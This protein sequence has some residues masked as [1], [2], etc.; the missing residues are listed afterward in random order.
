MESIEHRIFSDVAEMAAFTGEAGILY[1]LVFEDAID[2]A[3]VDKFAR[4]R[5]AC[6]RM[7]ALKFCDN[8][9]LFAHMQAPRRLPSVGAGA[10]RCSTMLGQ[11]ARWTVF[12]ATL[13][14]GR[15]GRVFGP[16]RT[17]ELGDSTGT[18]RGEK[19]S[20]V[21]VGKAGRTR[22][23][24]HLFPAG[25]MRGQAGKSWPTMPAPKGVR[26]ESPGRSPG[27]GRIEPA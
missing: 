14:D 4:E 22:G 9:Q 26:D 13:G 21:F 17:T 6:E 8:A 1:F 19:G 2:D 10:R 15:P 5:K 12:S 18:G 25:Q 3:F 23:S 16:D 20:D 27:I 24:G 11:L 7:I